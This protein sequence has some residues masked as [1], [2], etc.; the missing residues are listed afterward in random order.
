MAT[1]TR[2][3]ALL[4]TRVSTLPATGHIT[5]ARRALSSLV[6]YTTISLLIIKNQQKKIKKLINKSKKTDLYVYISPI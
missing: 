1:G 2:S 4:A 6:R 5:A 3:A